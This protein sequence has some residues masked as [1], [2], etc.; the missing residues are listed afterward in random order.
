[1]TSLLEA[2]KRHTTIVADTGDLAAIE[3][4]RPRDATT[5]PS[6][7]LK[8]AQQPQYRPL[9]ADAVA[10]P[11]REPRTPARPRTGRVRCAHPPPGRRSRLDRSR[12]P[13][14]VRHASNHRAGA[15]TDRPLRAPR[16]R[17]RAGADQDRGDL[18]RRTRRRIPRARRCPLQHH[19]ALLDGAGAG[20]GAGRRTLISPFVGR[21][22][23][24]H[25]KAAG[26]RWDETA[27]QGDNDPGVRSVRRSTRC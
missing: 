1:M 9:V 8:A 25:K 18:G 10:R 7:I 6:L 26:P 23:D 19:A 20:R 11:P 3:R 17:P 12:R 2:L 4:L 21:I 16:C 14:V 15:S 24:W 13:A 5:N 27:M 22:Y